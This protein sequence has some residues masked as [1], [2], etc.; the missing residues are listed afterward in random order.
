ML[1]A[2][3]LLYEPLGKPKKFGVGSL[4]LFWGILPTHD[5]HG[6]FPTQEWNQGLLHFRKILYQLSYQGNP[7]FGPT[8]LLSTL[9]FRSCLDG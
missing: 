4:S 1:E 3:S 9:I 5:L 6:I 7:S 2:D 8:P